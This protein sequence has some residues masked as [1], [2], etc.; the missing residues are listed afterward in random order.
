MLE[1]EVRVWVYGSG[2]GSY[3]ASVRGLEGVLFLFEGCVCVHRGCSKVCRGFDFFW[4]FVAQ[5]FSFFFLQGLGWFLTVF[6]NQG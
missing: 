1:F 6:Y 5:G 3:W 2:Q 4:G